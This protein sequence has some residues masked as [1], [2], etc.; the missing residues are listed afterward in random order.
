MR[1][2]LQ[3]KTLL[4]ITSIVSS[5]PN[6]VLVIKA[7][8]YIGIP[9]PCLVHGSKGTFGKDAETVQATEVFVGGP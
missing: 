9:A 4:P 3:K 1:E 5:T 2:P 7:P 8:T 6:Q